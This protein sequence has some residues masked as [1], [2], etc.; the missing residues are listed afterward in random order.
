MIY[1]TWKKKK[2]QMSFC[3]VSRENGT[4]FISLLRCPNLHNWLRVMFP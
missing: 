3:V 1:E 4:S 2:K